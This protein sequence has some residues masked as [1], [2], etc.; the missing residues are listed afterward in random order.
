MAQKIELKLDASDVVKSYRAAITAMEQAGAKSSITSGLTKSLDRLEQKFKDLANEGALG[1]ETSKE[2]ENFQKRV[3][4]THSSLGQ[5]GKE[6]ERLGKDKKTFPTS[7]INEFEKK[8]NEA[9]A[10]VIEIQEAFTK[11]FTKLGLTEDLAQTLKTEEDVRRVLE[12]QLKLR[13]KNVEEAKKA[14]DAAREE[15]SKSVKISV[16][17]LSTKNVCRNVSYSLIICILC[18]LS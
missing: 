13:Q 10:K 7:A 6:M 4:S 15:A 17:I 18:Y 8:I 1:K 9:K 14:A 2:I 12:E 11:Q 5:L 16:P 3:N